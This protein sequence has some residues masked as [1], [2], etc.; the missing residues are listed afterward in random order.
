MSGVNLNLKMPKK[1]EGKSLNLLKKKMLALHM[2]NRP[3][4]Y[5]AGIHL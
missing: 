3:V 5:F 2:Y 4:S 1:D